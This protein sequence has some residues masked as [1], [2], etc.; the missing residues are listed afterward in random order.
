MLQKRFFPAALLLMLASCAPQLEPVRE[1]LP[2]HLTVPRRTEV[3]AAAEDVPDT[4][5]EPLPDAEP[6]PVEV[7]RF[8][9]GI[10]DWSRGRLK[11]IRLA[12]ARVEGHVIG[13][14]ETFSFNEVVGPRTAALGY[15]EAIVFRGQE[16]VMEIGG[17]IC[18]LSTNLY[19]A[20]LQ[21]GLPILE[22]HVHSQPVDY[23]PEGEDATV[24]YG[25]LDLK[26][27]N[28]GDLP[29]QLSTLLQD[30]ELAVSITALPLV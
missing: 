16:K 8:V 15:Q 5:A 9:T 28:N 26:F 17:G 3:E 12:C 21:A 25:N 14:G 1:I 24:Y 6:A 27:V 4:S 18:Q 29:L 2:F 11:N 10:H 22:R 23:V 30:G 19:N 20:A 7:A 13:A